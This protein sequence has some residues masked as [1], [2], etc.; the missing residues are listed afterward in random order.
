MKEFGVKLLKVDTTCSRRV[1]L[2]WRSYARKEIAWDLLVCALSCIVFFFSHCNR[3]KI[4]FSYWIFKRALSLS[5]ILVC[6]FVAL[7]ICPCF[8]ALKYIPNL[9]LFC[10]DGAKG[11]E[12]TFSFSDC[13]KMKHN[14]GAILAIHFQRIDAPKVKKTILFSSSKERGETAATQSHLLVYFP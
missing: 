11:V 4:A 8:P 5:S 13:V 6:C 14:H 2:L 3:P 10:R 12:K 9:D 7:L 1:L